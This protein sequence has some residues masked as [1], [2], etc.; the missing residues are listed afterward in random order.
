VAT[1]Y[2]LLVR[3]IIAISK[4]PSSWA[5]MNVSLLTFMTV[6]HPDDV[7]PAA[8]NAEMAEP[9]INFR[10][11]VTD[12]IYP[13]SVRDLEHVGIRRMREGAVD[14]AL[15]FGIRGVVEKVGSKLERRRVCHNGTTR[16]PK[17]NLGFKNLLLISIGKTFWELLRSP[18]SFSRRKWPNST[19]ACR[20]QEKSM[21]FPHPANMHLD[22]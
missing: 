13:R 15:K 4:V 6:E 16:L 5:L 9:A 20:F 11:D 2:F 19:E 1:P 10:I 21:H 8:A 14:R 17:E 18:R 3:T 7:S 12:L 22:H